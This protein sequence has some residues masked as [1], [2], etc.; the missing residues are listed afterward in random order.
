MGTGGSYAFWYDF[1]P[2]TLD[3]HEH[4][5]Y[6]WQAPIVS[7]GGW[8]NGVTTGSDPAVVILADRTPRYPLNTP[9]PSFTMPYDWAYP[10]DTLTTNK[11]HMSQNHTLGEYINC[12]YVDLHVGNATKGNIGF[13]N[14]YIYGNPYAGNPTPTDDNQGANS[15]TRINHHIALTDSFLIGPIQAH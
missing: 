5:S 9:P 6:S 12:L 1:S 2:Y 8:A 14:D 7:G 15:E 10:G 3:Q 4:L 13:N 11:A